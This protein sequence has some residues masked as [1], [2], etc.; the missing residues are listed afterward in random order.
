ML[1]YTNM[2]HFGKHHIKPNILDL[3]VIRLTIWGLRHSGGFLH[4]GMGFAASEYIPRVVAMLEKFLK[5]KP[6]KVD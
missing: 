1:Y 5:E 4:Y 3:V 6:W 2:K